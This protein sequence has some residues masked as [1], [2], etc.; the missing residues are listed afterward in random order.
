M[1]RL[2]A[3]AAG[4]QPSPQ[5]P[6]RAETFRI[7]LILLFCCGLRRGELL[8]LRLAHFDSQQNL[9]RIEDTKFHKSRL[10]PLSTSV[11]GELRDYLDLCPQKHLSMEPERFLIWNR[12]CPEAQTRRTCNAFNRTWWRLCLSGSQ[13]VTVVPS[14]LVSVQAPP[15]MYVFFWSC[16][17]P[18]ATASPSLSD[19]Q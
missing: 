18:R 15:S 10:A 2:L 16:N 17:I 19:S 1:A 7:A 5:N 11:A 4:L 14:N 8:R 3:T 9:L 6:L 13:I 12:G